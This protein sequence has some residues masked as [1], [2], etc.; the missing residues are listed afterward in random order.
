MVNTPTFNS[1]PASPTSNIHHPLAPSLLSRL[2]CGTSRVNIVFPPLNNMALS[3]EG[4]FSRSCQPCRE[5]HALF[6]FIYTT[7]YT[8]IM[9]SSHSTVQQGTVVR[10]ID[11][12]APPS[13]RMRQ[14]DQKVCVWGGGDSE[15]DLKVC[16]FFVTL[17]QND[18]ILLKWC[19]ILLKAHP[20][21]LSPMLQSH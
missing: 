6:M 3:G 16:F 13:R 19:P 10:R 7:S 17:G 5:A 20:T 2:L 14:T 4:Q 9:S 21:V 18:W 15:L 8:L 1:L 11:D 12:Q